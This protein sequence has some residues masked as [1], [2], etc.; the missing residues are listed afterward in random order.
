[1]VQEA[2]HLTVSR[3][4]ELR[5]RVD[6]TQS[7]NDDPSQRTEPRLLHSPVLLSKFSARRVP[8]RPPGWLIICWPAN[9]TH[10]MRSPLDNFLDIMLTCQCY[11]QR[12]HSCA[13]HLILCCM[14]ACL[15][16]GL[17]LVVKCLDGALTVARPQKRHPN[18]L[19]SRSSIKFAGSAPDGQSCQLR[20][21]HNRLTRRV[22]LSPR[23]HVLA[24]RNEVVKSS[25]RLCS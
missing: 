3:R 7:K 12:C 24:P 22:I 17:L 13:S 5:R 18:L 15:L 19:M 8:R 1:M 4:A 23:C 6:T 10:P 11:F 2:S 20:S 25:S 9:N 21:P 16:N 14:Y